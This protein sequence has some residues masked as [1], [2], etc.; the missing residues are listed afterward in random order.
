MISCRLCP[1][2]TK[3]LHIWS[4]F[5]SSNFVLR[6]GNQINNLMSKQPTIVDMARKHNLST[7]AGGSRD[8]N[9][10]ASVKK[11]EF[12]FFYG[13]K[14][15]FSQMHPAQF[16]V[17]G[18]IY[19]CMEQYMHHQ[20][21]VTFKDKIRESQIM[22]TSD[23]KA[24][25]KLGRQVQNFDKAVWGWKSVAVVTKG[26]LA[27][28]RQN[29]EMKKA[30]YATYPKTLVEASPRDRL[31]GIGM[32]KDNPKAQ[33]RATWRGKNLLGD[34]L[35]EVRNKLMAEERLIPET[36]TSALPS[37][38]TPGSSSSIENQGQLNKKISLK[39]KGTETVPSQLDKSKSV[40]LCKTTG[41][42]STHYPSEDKKASTGTK[43]EQE[44]KES[45]SKRSATL[46]KERT[47]SKRKNVNQDKEDTPSKRRKVE[48]NLERETSVEKNSGSD[49]DRAKDKEA[50]PSRK[51]K[52][53]SDKEEALS[54]KTKLDSDSKEESKKRKKET[55]LKNSTSKDRIEK[56]AS[57]GKAK[58][59]EEQEEVR[60][61]K[62][63]RTS[64][65][66][67]D[68]SSESK[69]KHGE[70]HSSSSH[71]HVDHSSSSKDKDEK[72][73]S[74]SKH[75]E[76]NSSSSRHKKDKHSHSIDDKQMPSSLS[77][78]KHDDKHSSSSTHKH[79]KHATSSKE[80]HADHPSKH[81]HHKHSASRKH[82]QEKSHDVNKN[83]TS[84]ET[85]PM[86][87]IILEGTNEMAENKEK[88]PN[89]EQEIQDSREAPLTEK[90]ESEEKQTLEAPL[91][92]RIDSEEIKAYE[93]APTE[94]TGSE[95]TQALESQLIEKTDG[96]ETQ[97]LESPLMEKT[98][99]EETQA[100]EKTKE[101][102]PSENTGAVLKGKKEELNEE[103]MLTSSDEKKNGSTAEKV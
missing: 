99:G 62:D 66:G 3:T 24:Q 64:S 11:E 68:R 49:R 87:T 12:V 69:H 58:Q 73:R 91:T 75:D 77:S 33:N 57:D 37:T 56:T 60:P 97:A 36:S 7:Q 38:S 8:K 29:P 78:S 88:V 23:P 52:S 44:S 100:V 27:K 13:P 86:H 20:K 72:H 94:K 76:K 14:C 96:E 45:S 89:E 84:E 19:N 90:T 51:R 5:S 22:K 35:T 9:Q 63:K 48:F 47:P 34:T 79:G 17:D 70:H 43:K 54:K 81:R 101:T 39:R 55:D 61:S 53:T 93:A 71:E 95:E 85:E 74:S 10:K 30:L 46:E 83:S 41:V 15:V 42:I 1:Y 26:N 98:D 2:L 31:W 16:K 67:S 59:Y 28:Y 40:D 21:A 80:E 6:R 92:E 32:G 4:E 102:T 25:K 50:S 65:R 103:V 18:I 82:N